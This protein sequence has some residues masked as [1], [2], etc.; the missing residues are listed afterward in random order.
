[1]NLLSKGS[2]EL[3]QVQMD[4]T[5][6]LFWWKPRLNPAATTLSTSATSFIFLSWNIK[7]RWA[8]LLELG[9]PKTTGI[10][11]GNTFTPSISP[12]WC[13]SCTT[14][15]TTALTVVLIDSFS[16]FFV[17]LNGIWG[18]II[19]WRIGGK[20]R[21][22]RWHGRFSFGRNLEAIITIFLWF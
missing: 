19:G 3:F 16:L 4:T 15:S 20:I 1:M 21:G 2:N 13:F 11:Q 18:G 17:F 9:I 5:L 14:G 12:V 22:W 8:A 6:G 7:T 10:T